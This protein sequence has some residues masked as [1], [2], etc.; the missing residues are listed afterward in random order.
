MNLNTEQPDTSPID[1]ASREGLVGLLTSWKNSLLEAKQRQNGHP[2]IKGVVQWVDR[3]LDRLNKAEEPLEHTKIRITEFM[4]RMHLLEGLPLDL[5]F[6]TKGLRKGLATDNIR[7]AIER[8][9]AKQHAETEKKKADDADTKRRFEEAVREQ[10]DRA[11]QWVEATLP[12]AIEEQAAQGRNSLRLDDYSIQPEPLKEAI[13]RAVNQIKGLRGKK[14]R[15]PGP[16][17][18]ED[19]VAYYEVDVYTIEWEL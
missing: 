1:G 18:S 14:E 2:G 16:Y 4:G 13:I 9:K 3:T 6:E 19:T 12:R 5:T 17:A 11:A 15:R 7:A 10:R 8:G